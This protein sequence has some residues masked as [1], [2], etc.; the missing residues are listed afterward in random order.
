M[1]KFLIGATALLVLLTAANPVLA[2][3]DKD[4]EPTSWLYFQVIKD[5]N[6]KPV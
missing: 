4:E 2:Q 6:G 1:N 3:K 5:D